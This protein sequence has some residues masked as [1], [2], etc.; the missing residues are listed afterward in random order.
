MILSDFL[1]ATRPPIADARGC[2]TWLSSATLADPR[3]ACAALLSL[4]EDLEQSPPSH[5]EYLQI[6][7]KL[8]APLLAALIEHAKKFTAKPLPLGHSEALAFRQTCAL[9][10]AVHRSYWRLLRAGLKG[11]HPELNA[12]LALI[13][14]RVVGGAG[15]IIVAH[16]LARQT[17]GSDHWQTLHGAYAAAETLGHADTPGGDPALRTSASSIYAQALLMSLA[18][19]QGLTIREMQW[20][21]RWSTRWSPRVSIERSA[22]GSLRHSVDLAGGGGA[23]WRSGEGG[24]T[25]LRFLDTTI[26]GRTIRK[27]LKQLELGVAPAALGLGKDIAPLAAADLLKYLLRHWCQAPAARQFPRRGPLHT[28]A[29]AQIEV[30]IGMVAVHLSISGRPVSDERKPWEYSRQRAEQIQVFQH[31]DPSD[32]GNT[33]ERHDLEHW[34]PVD[35]SANGFRLQRRGPGARV[36]VGQLLSLRPQGAR[37]FILAEVRWIVQCEDNAIELGT[38]ALPGLANACVATDLQAD[39]LQRPSRAPAF[40]LPAGSGL[41]PTVVLP[42]GW[43]RRD[44][45]L[46]VR[47]AGTVAR[48]RLTELLDRGLDYERASFCV[49]AGA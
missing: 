8:R 32:G 44:R 14:M 42:F 29:P 46:E 4:L 43:Y 25:A 9:W 45:R 19:P 21:W 10:R 26:L 17:I 35:E 12:H 28:Q 22:A 15:E 38:R 6:L 16:C 40:L 49:D 7:E 30:A 24:G 41:Q 33:R 27:R 48:I 39:P 5:G 23:G 13:A 37:R 31:A 20:L 34:H 1:P 2:D 11:T 36:T 47:H 18:S 3:Q